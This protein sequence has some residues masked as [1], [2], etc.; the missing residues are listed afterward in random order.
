MKTTL[1][2]AFLLLSFL[3]CNTSSHGQPTYAE[4]ESVE[5]E[6]K[7][8]TPK[9]FQA[10]WDRVKSDPYT[11]LPQDEVSY[12]KLFT[13]AKDIIFE[14]ASRTLSEHSDIRDYFEKLAHPNGVCSRGIWKIEQE[15]PYSGY[16]KQGSEA[17]III[18][19]S[20]AMS[21]TKRGEIRAFGF[22]GKLF[23]TIDATKI[24]EQNSANFFVIDD[25]GGTD[26]E[27]FSDVALTNEPPISTN[28]EVLKYAAYA[29]KVADTFDAVDSHSTLR[30]LYEISE[31]GADANE[32]IITPKW[33]QIQAQAGQRRV[34]A[35]DF[36]DE[37][38]LARG[39]ALVFDIS[40]ASKESAE[41]VKEWQKIGTITLDAS[42]ASASCDH[43]LHFHHPKFRDDVLYAD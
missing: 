20:S 8:E 17:L 36:R 11:K 24:N 21:N 2:T 5:I 37:F 41:G 38:K 39:E 12:F 40:V 32:S 43:R 27:Y 42:V 31:L 33:M 34:D 15:N 28:S 9:Q 7:I 16:F 18:R 4:G 3:G 13:F 22:A 23:P 19:A 25:L 1:L 14:D 6:K 26:A 30:Q 29:L 35:E 10:V